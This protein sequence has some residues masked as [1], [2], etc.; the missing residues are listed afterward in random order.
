MH[1]EGGF[2]DSVSGFLFKPD[3]PYKSP[4]SLLEKL[5]VKLES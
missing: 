2:V 4:M 3:I 1:C 5:S